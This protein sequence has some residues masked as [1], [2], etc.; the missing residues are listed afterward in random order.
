MWKP[1]CHPEGIGADA[2]LL[3]GSGRGPCRE[4]RC[5]WTHD[6]QRIS[7][8]KPAACVAQPVSAGAR[9]FPSA[10]A[11]VSFP[12]GS[13]S[14]SPGSYSGLESVNPLIPGHVSFP[15]S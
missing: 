14:T 11:P 12:L 4:G 13:C 6:R 9:G 10:P 15:A 7:G 8:G 3:S 1:L 2:L 5:V